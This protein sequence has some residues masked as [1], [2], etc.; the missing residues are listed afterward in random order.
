MLLLSNRGIVPADRVSEILASLLCST[1]SNKIKE[2]RS[3]IQLPKQFMVFYHWMVI[4]YINRRLRHHMGYHDLC[5][6]A[7]KCCLWK[8]DDPLFNRGFCNTPSIE[9]F[10]LGQRIQNQPPILCLLVS[11]GDFVSLFSI[12]FCRLSL[13]QG[14]GV[15]G[16]RS[17]LRPHP[18][19]AHREPVP[20]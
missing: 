5:V 15:L 11:I 7:L 20:C 6:P 10:N 13:G 1:T 4:H 18:P 16:E 17:A 2:P 3:H 19:K 12:F 14:L 8:V 9:R